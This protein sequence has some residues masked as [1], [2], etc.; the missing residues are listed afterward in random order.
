MIILFI[1]TNLIAKRYQHSNN[2]NYHIECVRSLIKSIVILI[3][4]IQ[5]FYEST[6]GI[7][8]DTQIIYIFLLNTKRKYLFKER[9]Y[10]LHKII[11]ENCINVNLRSKKLNVIIFLHIKP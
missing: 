3:N 5:F 8:V 1:F 4:S 6:Y 9:C 10:N 11:T 2:N 7:Y